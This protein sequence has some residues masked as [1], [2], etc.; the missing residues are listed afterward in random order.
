MG[1]PNEEFQGLCVGTE[2]FYAINSQKS[3][4]QQEI[5]NKL[6]EWMYSA[7]TG[8][9]YVVNKFGFIAPFDT[10]TT[11]DVPDDPLGKQLMA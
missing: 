8:K 1:L 4:A 2:N 5:A 6:I 9:D 11:N 7:P 10:F 3:T